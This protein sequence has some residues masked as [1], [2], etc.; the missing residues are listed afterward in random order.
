[1]VQEI[2]H[3]VKNNL[4]IVLSLLGSYADRK[5]TDQNTVQVLNETQNKI[6]SMALIHQNL[7]GSGNFNS[8]S[9]SQYFRNLID[10]IQQTYVGT[11]SK[12]I[13]VNTTIED[14]SLETSLAIP[15]GLIVNE[16]FTNAYKYAFKNKD[17]NNQVDI[18][19]NQ[20]NDKG[21]LHLSI[22]DNGIGVSDILELEKSESFG[23]QIVKGLVE[24]L[25]G[26]MDI[27]TQ[28]G[29]SYDIMIPV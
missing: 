1:L 27:T 29:L 26:H 3:R 19:F 14:V 9:T 25:G 21:T 6:K 23:M 8:T 22:K 5:D 18:V 10:N 20:S 7:Y 13:K 11:M 17:D 12:S 2:H 4:Q 24:Q 15:L 28:I 16:L